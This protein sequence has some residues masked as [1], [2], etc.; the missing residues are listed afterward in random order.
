MRAAVSIR[1]G[2]WFALLAVAAVAVLSGLV[3][4]V[5]GT[6]VAGTPVQVPDSPRAGSSAACDAVIANS[7]AKGSTNFPGAEVE[8]YVAVDPGNAQHLVASFQQ[9]RGTDGGSNTDVNVYSIDGGAHWTLATTQ[10]AFSICGGATK[11]SAGYFQ[12]ATDPWVSF[13]SDGSTVYSISDSFNANGPAFGGASSIIVSRSTNG[14]VDWQAPVTLRVDQSTTV[15]N[16]KESVTADSTHPA[17]AYAA[18]DQL[19][20]PS[21]NA[22]PRAFNVSPA[23]RGPAYFSKT[24]DSGAT[25]STGRIIFDPGQ[26]NQTIGNEIVVPSAGPAAGTLIDGFNL[27][28]TKGGKGNHPSVSYNVALIRSTD[29]G[30]TWSQPVIVSPLADA[31]VTIA[32]HG[33]RTG[34]IIPQ[35]TTDPVTGNLYATWQDGSFSTTGAA[36]VAFSMSSDGGAHWSS[37]IRIDQAPGD[38]AAFTPQIAVA[39]DGTVGV[40]YYDLENATAGSPGLTD[41]YIVHCHVATSD[42]SSAASWASGGETRLST[43]GSFDMTTAPDAG[44]YFTGDYEGLASSGSVFDPFFVMA[45]PIATA[46]STDPFSNT[47]G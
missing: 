21:R 14:G 40:T 8:P 6:L 32:G 27:I 4:A 10:P 35:F 46:G 33:V 22:N 23:F 34:D 5:A 9:D 39:S 37:P 18:W 42:C 2:G 41:A 36:K 43:T 1:R 20:S 25:W 29:G 11:G 45:K 24:T 19:V 16:D 28:L 38:A 12:R 15:L 30:N 17:I 31:P 7:V 13:S 47:A 3:T 44:G 26:K